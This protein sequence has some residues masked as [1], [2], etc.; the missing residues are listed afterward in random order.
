MSPDALGALDGS[1]QPATPVWSTVVMRRI[2]RVRSPPLTARATVLTSTD[3]NCN[4]AQTN[5]A[6]SISA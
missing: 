3:R 1:R 5:D 4:M 6:T 2:A